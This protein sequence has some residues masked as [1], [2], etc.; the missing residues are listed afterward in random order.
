M[1]VPR[2]ESVVVGFDGS[3]ESRRA[4]WWAMAE[5]VSRGRPLHVVHA[6]SVPLEELT[7]VHLPSEA[8]DLET[9]RSTA[10]QEMDSLVTDCRRRF[11]DTDVAT[12][13]HM[14]HPTQVLAGAAADAE[15]LVLGAPT[16][17]RT[18][19]V[20]LGS[21]AAELVRKS[22]APLVVVREEL[23]HR[24]K[25]VDSPI[26]HVVVGVDG[27]RH[28]VRAIDFALDFAARHGAE[29]KAV[30]AWNELPTDAIPP[31]QGWRVDWADITNTCRRELAESLAGAAERYPELVIHHEVTTTQ[32]PAEALIHAAESA[33]LLVVGTRGRG[34]I[35]AA[36]LGSVSHAVV[37]YAPCPIA[38]VR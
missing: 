35:Q 3:P 32:S 31:H 24:D 29:L 9:L 12:E 28:S 13:V 8:L 37:H 15:L 6:Y 30:L 7:R 26:E 16:R 22:P 18:R 21:T 27:S 5:A 34:T 23:D 36:L 10:E 25:S 1:P 14:G 11:P 33:D 2:T 38:V 17:S 20:L 19:S 4:V